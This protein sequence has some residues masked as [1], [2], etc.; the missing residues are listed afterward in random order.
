[1]SEV[2][3][4]TDKP[5]I[6][7]HDCRLNRWTNHL[8]K[9]FSWPTATVALPFMAASHPVQGDTFHQSELKVIMEVGFLKRPKAAGPDESFFKDDG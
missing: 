4:E 8:R 2:I 5:L 7:Y 3:K 9:Q 1:M 6:H